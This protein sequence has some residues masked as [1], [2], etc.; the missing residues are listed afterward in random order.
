MSGDGVLLDTVIVIDHLNGIERATEF[1]S[2]LGD[3]ARLSAI[4]RAEVLAGLDDPALDLARRLL[5]RL[6][7]LVIDSPVADIAATFRRQRRWRLPDALQAAVAVHHGL[8]LATRNTRDFDP[9]RD[10]FV[11]VPYVV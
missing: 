10:S 6:P 1:M 2:S 7:M 4:T 5:N 11:I 9:A 3:R 8:Q